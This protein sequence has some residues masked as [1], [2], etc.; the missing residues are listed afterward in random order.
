MENIVLKNVK[1]FPVFCH[2]IKTKYYIKN[3]RHCSLHNNVMD[4]W[5]KLY[6]WMRRDNRDNDVQKIKV[7]KS[8]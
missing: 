3:M 7:E 6:W 1:K 4:R 2:K 8:V 5:L